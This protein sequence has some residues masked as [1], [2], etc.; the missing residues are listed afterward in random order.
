M[1]YQRDNPSSHRKKLEGFSIT[2]GYNEP[3]DS[4]DDDSEENEYCG[5]YRSLH[6]TN[7]VEQP[8]IEVPCLNPIRGRYVKIS[9]VA[10]TLTMCEV[11]VY[12]EP[13]KQLS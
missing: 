6:T 9:G 3:S 10:S 11:E 12:A 4:S 1:L 5:G 8:K 7:G 2:I 13:S